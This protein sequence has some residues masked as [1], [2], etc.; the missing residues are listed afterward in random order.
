MKETRTIAW[1]PYVIFDMDGTLLDSMRLYK[2]IF[3]KTVAAFGIK[4][5]EAK[6]FYIRSAGM[7]LDLQLEGVFKSAGI[8][9]GENKIRA[10]AK[11]FRKEASRDKTKF[12]PGAKK[13][14]R[15]L[16]ARG[17]TVMISSGASDS[18]IAERLE[19]G[20]IAS[21]VSHYCGS[22]VIPKSPAHISELA[23]R[24]NIKAKDLGRYGCFCGDGEA[25]MRIA[26]QTGL[27]PIGISGT[28]SAKLLYAAGAERVVGRISD[29]LKELPRL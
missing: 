9:L 17:V 11:Q 18:S 3:I 4:A 7:P 10:L 2:R 1:F 15:E 24:L 23:R 8:G 16:S 13:L 28:V 12:F 25:D 27:Y 29:L 6:E 19:A 20:G 26:V 22:S 14:V 5:E 21:C